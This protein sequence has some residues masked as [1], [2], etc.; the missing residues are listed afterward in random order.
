MKD[1]LL[2][3]LS[4]L[5]DYIAKNELDSYMIIA[6]NSTAKDYFIA[7][8]FKDSPNHLMARADLSVLELKM[9]VLCKEQ[10]TLEAA[11]E[12]LHNT[13]SSAQETLHFNK[14]E[15]SNKTH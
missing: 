12:V 13:Q 10:D 1:I 8:N 6:M 7:Y 15:K 9:N 5:Q 4:I 3:D 2:K 14:V 11:A